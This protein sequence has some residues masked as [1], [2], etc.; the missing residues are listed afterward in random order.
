MTDISNDFIK[1]IDNTRPVFF[2]WLDGFIR[3]DIGNSFERTFKFISETIGPLCVD[4]EITI[5]RAINAGIQS[6]SDDNLY[7]SNHDWFEFVNL[8]T[9]VKTFVSL[10][11]QTQKI[12]ISNRFDNEHILTVKVSNSNYYNFSDATKQL[13][14]LFKYCI[15][16][17]GDELHAI[18]ILTFVKDNKMYLC[19]VNSGEGLNETL[20]PVEINKIP[21]FSPHFSYL[22]C[23]DVSN[24]IKLESA[25]KSIIA[26]LEF[27]VL[28]EE[29]QLVQN[30]QIIDD[31]DKYVIDYQMHNSDLKRLEFVLAHASGAHNISFGSGTLS[32]FAKITPKSFF[33]KE[34]YSREFVTTPT[35]PDSTPTEPESTPEYIVLEQKYEFSNKL[36]KM[37]CL[38]F[39]NINTKLTIPRE[40]APEITF[41][42]DELREPNTLSKLVLEKMVFQIDGSS[43]Y[44]IDQKSGSCTWYSM[45]WPLL[46]YNVYYEPNITK[47]K[48]FVKDINR[49]FK[50]IIEDLFSFE[51]FKSIFPRTEANLW[52][53]YY[54]NFCN[55]GL[56]KRENLEQYTDFLFNSKF[57]I[58][59]DN[60]SIDNY[61]P[62]TKKITIDSIITY[63]GKLVNIDKTFIGGLLSE[64]INLSN[65]KNKFIEFTRRLAQITDSDKILISNT[66]ILF[67]IF[68]FN[69]LETNGISTNE[70]FNW[71]FTNGQI[72]RNICG[73]I[74][75]HLFN[76][77]KHSHMIIDY[78][79]IISKYETNL[80]QWFS[81]LEQVVINPDCIQIYNFYHWATMFSQENTLRIKPLAQFISQAFAIS[82]IYL[83][84][85]NLFRE[86]KTGNKLFN[87]DVEVAEKFNEFLQ[88]MFVYAKNEI[89]K[90][91][92]PTNLRNLEGFFDFKC[93]NL[94]LESNYLKIYNSYDF[95][96]K[97]NSK[98]LIK[99]KTFEDFLEQREFFYANPE[100]IYSKFSNE[101]EENIT[102][103][104][105]IKINISDIIKP[106]NI[107]HRKTLLKFYGK[108]YAYYHSNTTKQQ[109]LF[110]TLE[111]LHLL[112]F[113]TELD[114]IN[115][116]FKNNE[117]KYLLAN[118]VSLAFET[119][120]SQMLKTHG[121]VNFPQYLSDNFE[122]ISETFID[123]LV[124]QL[125]KT[126]PN[127]RNISN[128]IYIG[129]LYE[130]LD[131][132]NTNKTNSNP[133]PNSFF[134]FF[135]SADSYPIVLVNLEAVQSKTSNIKFIIIEGNYVFNIVGTNI[136]NELSISNIFVN[137]NQVLKLSELNYPFKYS[138][139]LTCSHLFFKTSSTTNV[140]YF[141]K[142]YNEKYAKSNFLN[143]IKMNN[144]ILE[145][146]INESTMLYPKITDNNTLLKFS[147]LCLNYHIRP[148]NIFYAKPSDS[149][150]FDIEL[151]KLFEW[152][153]E[154]FL[155]QQFSPV[156][157]NRVVLMNKISDL[158]NLM[159]T[160]SK[161][162]T[163]PNT[164]L[165]QLVNLSE[166]NIA[167]SYEKLL[168][169][170]E[171]C[172]I[173]DSNKEKTI[174]YLES[175]LKQIEAK[176][177][178]LIE[179]YKSAKFR[180][181]FDVPNINY[182]GLI[183]ISNTVKQ[184][185]SLIDNEN[186]DLFCSQLKILRELFN[187]RK[188]NCKYNFE[189]LFE[190]ISGY[191]LLEE[192]QSRYFQII[193]NY[194]TNETKPNEKEFTDQATNIIN[195]QQVG[196]RIYPLH[197]FMMGK[198]KSSVM[199]PLLTLYFSLIHNL[200]PVIIVP[201]HLVPDTKSIVSQYA[202]VFSRGNACKVMS[203]TEIKNN[204]LNGDFLDETTNSKTV[205]IIDEFDSL[206]DPTKSNFNVVKE[207]TVSTFTLFNFIN[208]VVKLLKT[209][210]LD[211]VTIEQVKS[212]ESFN[213]Y[214]Y[215]DQVIG[216]IIDEIN[217]TFQNIKSGIFVENIHWGIDKNKYYAVPYANKDK[218][219]G[220][221]SFSSSV[222]TIFLT[223]YY[224]AILG[225]FAISDLIVNFVVT[226]NLYTEL[227][228]TKEPDELIGYY[229]KQL[230]ENP[231]TKS[232]LF[233][234]FFNEIF[235]NFKLPESQLN[236]SFVD[237]VNIDGIYKVGYSGTVNIDFPKF[238]RSDE[239]FDLSGV[240]PD[241]DE[242]IN[243]THALIEANTIVINKINEFKHDIVRLHINKI[244]EKSDF[245]L[246]GAFI[247][248]VGVFKNIPNIQV[249]QTFF[250]YFNK[251]RNVIFMSE[252]DVKF[253]I[254]DTGLENYSSSKKYSNPFI[255]YS[256]GHVVGVD[257][258]QDYLPELKGLV[259]INSKSTYT[260][261][262]QSIFRLRKINLGHTIDILFISNS[263]ETDEITITNSID[264]YNLIK[265]NDEKF[266]TNKHDLL[267]YQTL[268]SEVRKNNLIIP[269][270]IYNK[271]KDIEPK[272][273]KQFLIIRFNQTYTEK[274]K[275]YYI[276]K[277]PTNYLGKIEEYFSGIIDV[278]PNKNQFARLVSQINQ[279]EKL[280]KLVYNIGSGC[281]EISR[282]TET[283]KIKVKVS[284][285]NKSIETTQYIPGDLAGV[286][287]NFDYWQYLF[288]EVSHP[289]IFYR[290]TIKV[291]DLVYC[292]PNISSQ[293]NGNTFVPNKSGLVFVLIRK[294]NK[295]LL[296]PGYMSHLFYKSHLL[297]RI[298]NLRLF[299]LNQID[300]FRQNTELIKSLR[301]SPMIKFISSG[302]QDNFPI[303]NLSLE[304]LFV[305]K[306]IIVNLINKHKNHQQIIDK[307]NKKII[308]QY[309]D[310]L[311][312]WSRYKHINQIIIPN[313]EQNPSIEPF[314]M[315]NAEYQCEKSKKIYWIEY[316]KDKETNQNQCEDNK[317][318][319]FRQIQSNKDKEK[320]LIINKQKKL[321]KQQEELCEFNK[322]EYKDTIECE[323]NKNDFVN[324]PNVDLCRKYKVEYLVI[325]N[326]LNKEEMLKISKRLDKY[327]KE[328][329]SYENQIA[330]KEKKFDDII[331]AKEQIYNS[332]IE[333]KTNEKN[334]NSILKISG[335]K[336][337]PE[338][339][340]F[341]RDIDRRVTLIQNKIEE[342]QLDRDNQIQKIIKEK[343]SEIKKIK[344]K[345]LP[346]NEKISKYNNKII[347]YQKIAAKIEN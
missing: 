314:I 305:L 278:P 238:I 15:F 80:L 123:K 208:Q 243:V 69:E 156:K 59:L 43:L 11:P 283:E 310:K 109:E 38:F 90:D 53:M 165:A 316:K 327:N 60:I 47:Y 137:N 111:N 154:N 227:F 206:I 205:F 249:A 273:S 240:V 344:I 131:L 252:T 19:V 174:G 237:I 142:L 299:N 261:V 178:E 187:S 76:L 281:Q 145:F 337:K 95:S 23:D 245:N 97:T 289:D 105:F 93:E 323:T 107:I 275:Y 3:K 104:T 77:V 265:T 242:I 147:N 158:D 140:I 122:E 256:Q 133:V 12:I 222:L 166:T 33:Y 144:E 55:I 173:V 7:K 306:V 328:K 138:M 114:Q 253:V 160:T 31:E 215:S 241:T 99:N 195:Y 168:D 118:T 279:S 329:Q 88:S 91:F 108:K 27:N 181:L 49:I 92:F 345:I 296:I 324:I 219:I 184:L 9:N 54:D 45:Y 343:E 257:I 65:F 39:N 170:I 315:S 56:L 2:H 232:K 17:C 263:D 288:N 30:E 83:E 28:Y 37:Y 285:V 167:I 51:T 224:Y 211:Y 260:N 100:Y 303:D 20:N 342:I 287:S 293:F 1:R 304:E 121:I 179:F 259:T 128:K 75:L 192:Q 218:P 134:K 152:T 209:N 161:I 307:V 347:E 81:Y 268:K 124:K 151:R 176:Q 21:C 291:N 202:K 171:S 199:T 213:S 217:Q 276:D 164:K 78:N 183:K 169:K 207:K 258:R 182:M 52:M 212:F 234:R 335:L 86:L 236:T 129:E 67:Y 66:T 264:V 274:I 85:N 339:K 112:I 32:D 200:N 50:C 196:G 14:D 325:F 312:T 231:Q 16:Q 197:H 300:Q 250:K 42:V 290:I 146:T 132:K 74:R 48:N 302:S 115:S 35:E 106:V 163:Q 248:Q 322:Q 320:Q 125:K 44:I 68:I 180:D 71:N 298:D 333:E 203:D 233:E 96:A 331:K 294:I 63:S 101:N 308:D 286:Q 244:T 141:V 117:L 102:S 223:L 185:L 172:R 194:D 113:G 190:I 46:M 157:T 135:S 22:I 175:L 338:E 246:Y 220:N 266:K 72:K 58:S 119:K 270:I 127:T 204:F 62:E 6:E 341:N 73:K 10:E 177:A 155:K 317:N 149:K 346:V 229:I 120:L 103:D 61:S 210:N 189:F 284:T 25:L 5:A 143:Q 150:P 24:Q 330:D 153:D 255:Y 87:S 239:L 198:G 230:C 326:E 139:P 201:E 251:T 188:Y 301:E 313:D 319:F 186:E 36:Y 295:L 18:S 34:K 4:K 8:K 148:L 336:L 321:I 334:S 228:E 221:S 159:I 126:Y 214:D 280:N 235:S 309:N 318:K 340:A 79:S 226:N 57:K 89:P 116:S 254:T 292:V 64:P 225:N 193:N 262:A 98:R 272:K 40:I 269:L 297:L 41:N 282:A 84:I 70:Y 94:Y 162:A 271:N 130:L 191:E 82:N 332:Q 110:Y 311:F 26:A 136:G 216:Y 247:D 277:I 13:S 29:L 267:I